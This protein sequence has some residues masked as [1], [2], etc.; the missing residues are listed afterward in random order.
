MK[1]S[2]HGSVRCAHSSSGADKQI[3]SA[4]FIS[5]KTVEK[6]VGSLL[7]KT[8]AHNRTMLV[9]MN[10]EHSSVGVIAER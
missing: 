10:R 8:G 6:H 1:L 2:P 4:L 7:R 5:V 9:H 3:A